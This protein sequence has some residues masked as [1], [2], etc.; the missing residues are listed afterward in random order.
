ML[1]QMENAERLSLARMQAVLQASEEVRFV[2]QKKRRVYA[3]VQRT[4]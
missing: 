1:I 4:W 3:W 2:G